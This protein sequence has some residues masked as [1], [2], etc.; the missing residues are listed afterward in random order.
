MGL[1]LQDQV[2][3]RVSLSLRALGGPLV[4]LGQVAL[5]VFVLGQSARREAVLEPL[6]RPVDDIVL[7]AALIVVVA[8][9]VD[10]LVAVRLVLEQV[11]PWQPVAQLIRVGPLV[12]DHLKYRPYKQPVVPS[13]THHI[14]PLSQLVELL[15]GHFLQTP[16]PLR[17]PFTAITARVVA[18][19]LFIRDIRLI[20]A[21]PRH[22]R[23]QSILVLILS[24]QGRRLELGHGLI[25]HVRF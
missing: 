24:E 19:D 6:A 20:F 1:L 13:P 9:A 14:G 21:N 18:I 12:K 3:G 7:E 22:W 15:L 2:D 17:A 5:T 4:I 10:P 25:V 11:V 16:F 23:L 8:D